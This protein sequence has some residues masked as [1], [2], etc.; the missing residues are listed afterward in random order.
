MLLLQ[1]SAFITLFRDRLKKPADA[2]I[3]S[4]EPADVAGP[5]AIKAIFADVGQNR[6]AATRKALGY[7]ESGGSAKALIDAARVLIFHKG[8]N[9]HD[10]KFSSA[11]L[12]DYSHVSPAWRHRYLA[13]NTFLLRGSGA[14]DNGLLKRTRAALMPS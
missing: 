3:D 2:R 14:P 13:A 1:G 6:M 12:E 9:A 10:Y 11:A 5:G 7:L 8:T 4:I